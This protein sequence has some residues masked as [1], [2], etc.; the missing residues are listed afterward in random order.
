M[1]SC[2]YT[3]YFVVILSMTVNIVL[4][5]AGLSINYFKIL[6]YFM[7][8]TTTIKTIYFNISDSR[9]LLQI[10]NLSTKN[11]SA[12]YQFNYYFSN[13][14]TFFRINFYFHTDVLFRDDEVSP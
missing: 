7:F 5:I 3:F 12:L 10:L 6:F 13:L 11:Q 4:C 1:S 8:T 14:K 2:I 9:L